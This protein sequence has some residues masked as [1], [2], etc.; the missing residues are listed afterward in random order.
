MNTSQ[1]QIPRGRTL[2]R[3]KRCEGSQ[4]T[5]CIHS[6]RIIHQLQFFNQRLLTLHLAS[7]TSK[8]PLRHNRALQPPKNRP[9]RRGVFQTTVQPIDPFP[10]TKMPLSA[11]TACFISCIPS[12]GHLYSHT[13]HFSDGG[14][15]V[16]LIIRCL[17]VVG[18]LT[19]ANGGPIGQWQ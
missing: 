18:R 4:L 17:I 3:D 9:T 6:P 11:F 8:H 14:S 16:F 15:M 2:M 7:N 10:S 13:L 1:L 12:S 5:P 19:S